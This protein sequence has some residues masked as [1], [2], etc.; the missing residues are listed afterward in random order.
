MLDVGCQILV[1]RCWMSGGGCQISDVGCKCQTQILHVICWI[2]DVRCQILYVGSQMSDARL[3]MLDIICQMLNFR[4]CIS[5][6]SVGC[7]MSD[8]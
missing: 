1:V 3:L 2:W 7:L 4:C 5:Y 8:V 6:V